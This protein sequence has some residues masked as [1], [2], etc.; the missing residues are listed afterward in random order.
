MFLNWVTFYFLYH[1]IIKCGWSLDFYQSFSFMFIQNYAIS[2]NNQYNFLLLT[3]HS[4]YSF[5]FKLS[6][7]VFQ[8]M[9]SYRLKSTNKQITI[10]P[11]NLHF[12]LLKIKSVCLAADH[13]ALNQHHVES[14][15][16]YLAIFLQVTSHRYSLWTFW[17][18]ESHT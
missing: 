10:F 17:C 16:K 4:G 11:F 14:E 12:W 18:I 15:I 7:I 13:E 3:L 2:L 6:R 5:Q 9:T 1:V 8:L